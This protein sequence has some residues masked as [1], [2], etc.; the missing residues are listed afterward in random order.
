M[1]THTHMYRHT[2]LLFLTEKK[3]QGYQ[4]ICIDNYE[5][6]VPHIFLMVHFGDIKGL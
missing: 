6:L 4:N 1:H 3:M 5:I 2:S